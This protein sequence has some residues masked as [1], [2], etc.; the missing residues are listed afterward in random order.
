MTDLEKKEMAE[1][2]QGLPRDNKGA[3]A[4]EDLLFAIDVQKWAKEETGGNR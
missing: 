1:L 2:I 4:Y 3:V